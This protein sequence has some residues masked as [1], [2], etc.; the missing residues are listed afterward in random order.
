ML[1]HIYDVCKCTRYRTRSI[2]V[3]INDFKIFV[4]AERIVAQVWGIKR[5][6]A[7]FVVLAKEIVKQSIVKYT[8]YMNINHFVYTHLRFSVTSAYG[9]K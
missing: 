1:K 8:E 3:I 4:G 6:F 9:L 7:F 2:L 5:F